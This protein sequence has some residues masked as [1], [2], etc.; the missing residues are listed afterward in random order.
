MTEREHALDQLAVHVEL[1]TARERPGPHLAR[2]HVD[3][4]G[5]LPQRRDLARVLHH[6]DRRRHLRR[7]H[8]GGRGQRL[9]EIEHEARPRVVA[10]RGERRAAPDDARH[11]RNRVV[12]LVPRHELEQVGPQRH[13]WR[14]EPRHHQ[15]GVAALRENE[16]REALERHRLVADEVRQVGPDRQQ[17]HVDPELGHARPDARDSCR[18]LAHEESPGR[19]SMLSRFFDAQYVDDPFVALLLRPRD[20]AVTVVD[21]IHQRHR[22]STRRRDPLDVHLDDRALP[23]QCREVRCQRV[24]ARRADL[25]HGAAPVDARDAR[26]SRERAGHERDASVLAQVRDRLDAA[27]GQVEV[28]D[29]L[30]PEDAQRVV[31]LW[32]QIDVPAVARRRG[33]DEEH[34]LLAPPLR[35]VGRKRGEAIGHASILSAG[36]VHE[37]KESG[38]DH[39]TGN[40]RSA[41]SRA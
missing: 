8:E 33:R 22:V 9:L 20:Q 40:A 26:I 25:V 31:S 34:R 30:R 17:E 27:A 6:A 29:A 21:E 4:F 11:D 1:G 32:R 3:R 37:R 14:F 12:G 35:K 5:R 19:P 39:P 23:R 18:V 15:P 10:D 41:P 2:D 28:G 16:H 13:P 36:V 38:I 7:A 24:E